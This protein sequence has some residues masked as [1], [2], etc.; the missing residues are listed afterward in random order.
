[1]CGGAIGNAL[2][3]LEYGAVIDF[4]HYTIP[5]VISNVS[6]LADHAIVFGVLLLVLESWRG[7]EHQAKERQDVTT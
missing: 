5:G 1:V 3:R 6:N 7:D 2:D 4:I